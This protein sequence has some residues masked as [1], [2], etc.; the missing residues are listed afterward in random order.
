MSSDSIELDVGLEVKNSKMQRRQTTNE[1]GP[2]HG[3]YRF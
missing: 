3:K 1:S 2:I